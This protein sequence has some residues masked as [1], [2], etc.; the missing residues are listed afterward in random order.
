MG[1][2]I[3]VG[4]SATTDAEVLE[5]AIDETLQWEGRLLIVHCFEDAIEIELPHPMFHHVEEE[6]AVL[7][8]AALV[9]RSRHVPSDFKLSDGPPGRALVE[10]SRGAKLLVIGQTRGSRVS[11]LARTSIVQYCL[12]KA[13]CPVAIVAST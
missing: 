7:D 11:Q 10:L 8:R 6:Q 9:A 13:H 3:V 4:I 12:K 1:P 5:W 2:R